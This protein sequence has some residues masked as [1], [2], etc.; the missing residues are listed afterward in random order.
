MNELHPG[1]WPDDPLWVVAVRLGDGRRV[2]FGRD[3]V[4][5]DLGQAVRGSTAV[6]AAYQ[7]API[8]TREY[9]DGGV[10]SS[11]NA[12]LTAPLGF[13]LVVVSSAMTATEGTGNWLSQPSRTWFRNKLVDEVALVRSAG[14]AV[15]VVEPDDDAIDQ[16]DRHAD[17]ARAQAT[18]AGAASLERALGGPEG[19][20]LQALI[21]RA[22]LPF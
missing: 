8:G 17:N 19:E 12:D 21:A 20:G 15:L 7:P 14:T 1:G 9:I 13:D 6:P 10:H 11:T 18:E 5:G 22:N 4:R 3:D 16:L 2:V